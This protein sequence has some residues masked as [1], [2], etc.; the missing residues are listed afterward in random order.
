MND[1]SVRILKETVV[2]SIKI[3]CQHLPKET[4]KNMKQ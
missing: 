3:L 2:T 1:I 4:E